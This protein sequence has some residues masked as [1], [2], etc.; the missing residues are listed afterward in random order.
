MPYDASLP[1]FL[2]HADVP[3]INV[4]IKMLT[5]YQINMYSF[6][7]LLSSSVPYKDCNRY[8]FPLMVT[9]VA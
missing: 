4:K 6:Y 3:A 8:D 5:F 9:T 1:Q 7:D 2:F